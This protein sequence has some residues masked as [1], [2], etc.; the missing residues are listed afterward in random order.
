MGEASKAV[1]FAYLEEFAGGDV[2]LMREV[3]KVFSG[4]AHGW[5]R[6]L[7]AG[8]KDWR[9]IVHTMKGTGRSVGANGLGDLCEQ[10]EADGPEL[11]PRIRA[12]LDEVIAEVDAWLALNGG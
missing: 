6:E 8:P 5:A 11:L 12:E 10:A 4:E 7:E 9:A 1:N 3:L 2:G